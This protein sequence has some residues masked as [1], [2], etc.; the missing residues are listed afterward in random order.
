M[1][2]RKLRSCVRKHG[3]QGYV[4]ST[5]SSPIP[6]QKNANAKKS[7]VICPLP[8]KCRKT[9]KQET[10]GRKP[11]QEKQIK[12]KQSARMFAQHGAQGHMFSIS[13]SPKPKY[14]TLK[15]N[16]KWDKFS[17]A[18]KKVQKQTADRIP[19]QP[20]KLNKA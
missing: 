19:C 15:A 10:A 4:G 11:R 13:S 6:K 1:K 5:S 9:N 14:T 3:A 12:S 2:T 7:G 18:R 20:K 17:N 16:N 8:K